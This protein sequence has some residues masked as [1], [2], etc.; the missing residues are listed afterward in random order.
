MTQPYA[1]AWL[2][3]AYVDPKA[4]WSPTASAEHGKDEGEGTHAYAHQAPPQPEPGSTEEFVGMSWLSG[5]T[6]MLGQVIDRTDNESH[7]APE[8]P[9]AHA[10]NEGAARRGYYNNGAATQFAGETYASVPFTSN[11]SPGVSNVALR[12]GMNSLP[13]N[14]PEGYPVGQ[15]QVNDFAVFRKFA[16]GMRRHDRR[17]VTPNTAAQVTN[18]PTPDQGNLL[19]SPYDSLARPFQRVFQRPGLRREPPSVSD[20]LQTDATPQP[21]YPYLATGVVIT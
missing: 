19:T 14:N 5:M 2:R 7:E 12:R 3:S 20:D 6:D 15:Q 9:G 17:V 18:V 8:G 21:A 11:P 1:G 4:A 10:V 16:V 13:E